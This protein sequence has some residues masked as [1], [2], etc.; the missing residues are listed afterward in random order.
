MVVEMF[1]RGEGDGFNGIDANDGLARH[2]SSDP[3]RGQVGHRRLVSHLA[4]QRFA[5]GVELAR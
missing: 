2:F 5:R 4:P 3:T 1:A